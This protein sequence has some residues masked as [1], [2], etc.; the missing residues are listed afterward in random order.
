MNRVDLF[1]DF[2]ETLT[3]ELLERILWELYWPLSRIMRHLDSA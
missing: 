1:C 2:K 3:R